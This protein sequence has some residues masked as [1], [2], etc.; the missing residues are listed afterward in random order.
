MI[1]FLFFPFLFQIPDGAFFVHKGTNPEVDSYSAFFDNLKS[2]NSSTGLNNHLLKDSSASTV[3]ICGLATD[4][5][6]GSTALDALDL[7]LN[8]F[9][10]LDAS[11]GIGAESS[12]KMLE[13]IVA[14]GGVILNTRNVRAM[15]PASSGSA[16][17]A[18]SGVILV[19]MLLVLTVK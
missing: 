7:G 16:G 13:N 2:V 11:R 17:L 6:V 12:E 14:K 10:V 18:G 3:F 19:T 15:M 4:Y 5:C 9:V 8:T 1:F